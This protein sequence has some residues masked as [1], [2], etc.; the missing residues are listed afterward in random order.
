MS[1]RTKYICTLAGLLLG[2]PAWAEQW[3]TVADPDPRSGGT[4]VE[5]D[6][7]TVHLR[8]P[9]GEGVIRVTFDVLQ[10]HAAGFGFRSVV[11]SAQFDCQRRGIALT[12]SAYYPLPQ[13]K[14]A[15]VGAESAGREAGMPPELLEKIPAPAR[16]AILKAA[17]PPAQN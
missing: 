6:L 11:A 1:L 12:S 14:G 16:L 17:C 7:E 4:L 2:A 9:G 10:P 8:S 13:G 5:I 3:F 15:R